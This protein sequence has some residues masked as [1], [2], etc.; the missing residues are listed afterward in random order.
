M[1]GLALGVGCRGAHGNQE[2]VEGCEAG[3][4]CS[5]TGD[6]DPDG[7]CQFSAVCKARPDTC[8]EALSCEC[9]IDEELMRYRKQ[10]WSDDEVSVECSG[11][12]DSGFTVASSL[13]PKCLPD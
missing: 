4:Y 3:A 5:V 10:G 6:R 8:A 1:L 2:C 12:P 13:T 9:L 7:G 11:D